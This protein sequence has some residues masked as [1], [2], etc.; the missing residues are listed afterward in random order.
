MS[1][2]RWLPIESNPDVMNKFLHAIGLPKKW[3]ISD[4][5]GLDPELLAMLP[6]PVVS[7]MLLF[8]IS[9][10]YVEFAKKQEAELADQKTSENLFYMKQTISNACGTVA[11]I[12][13]VANNLDSI[14]LEDGSLKDF[15][16]KAKDKGPEE[17]AKLLEENDK[18]CD[19]HDVV[20]KEGQ[21]NAPS[22]DDKVEYHYVAFVQK[23][24]SLYELDG[25]KSGPVS[26]GDCSKDDFLVNAANECKK[27]M[28][29][30]PENINFTVVALCSE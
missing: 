8:P 21:T 20:A 15:L 3:I 16:D 9:K 17:R 7:L 26:L 30:D 25:R 14:Q 6:Q 11:M 2:Q 19:A 12:H 28:A 18:V 4:V 24:G 10:N 1:I 22:L 23:D 5:F 13:A 29:R 27:Y